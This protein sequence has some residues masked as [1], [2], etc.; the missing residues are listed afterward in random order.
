MDSGAIFS[1]LQATVNKIISAFCCSLWYGS[2]QI[3]DVNHMVFWPSGSKTY[4]K[5]ART[6][7]EIL[8]CSFLSL[9]TALEY[10]YNLKKKK[11]LKATNGFPSPY[12]LDLKITWITV[13]ASYQ[14]SSLFHR[15][16]IGDT[17]YSVVLQQDT[18]SL[19]MENLNGLS[20]ISRITTTIAKTSCTH[21]WC[22]AS[23]Y[24]ESWH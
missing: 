23:W 15:E 14:M 9:W 17:D 6:L 21:P 10:F 22:N 8:L 12:K 1:F 18:I 16:V 13:F 5:S 7:K 20:E 24:V 11:K 2:M 3:A 4:P 19:Y